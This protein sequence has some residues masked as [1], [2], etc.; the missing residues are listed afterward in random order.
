MFHKHSTSS[1]PTRRLGHPVPIPVAQFVYHRRCCCCCWLIANEKAVGK[2]WRKQTSITMHD[3][4]KTKTITRLAAHTWVICRSPASALLAA[5]RTLRTLLRWWAIE[6]V[7]R[8]A[9]IRSTEK[10]IWMIKRII[11]IFHDENVVVGCVSTFLSTAT[12]QLKVWR[13]NSKWAKM[14]RMYGRES[15]FLDGVR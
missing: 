5:H 10:K 12:E 2:L 9:H 15:T 1:R 4:C 3:S 6:P 7:M 14:V 8:V 13:C 11:Q